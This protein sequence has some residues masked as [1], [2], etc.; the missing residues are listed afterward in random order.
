[1]KLDSWG[2]SPC[3]I[4]NIYIV[5]WT[6]QKPINPF[7][8][9][10]VHPFVNANLWLHLRYVLNCLN[11]YCIWPLENLISIFLSK[12]FSLFHL[13][14]CSLI[15]IETWCL[16]QLTVDIELPKTCIAFSISIPNN[17]KPGLMG[18][19]KKNPYSCPF[20][21]ALFYVS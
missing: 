21:H 8:R 13:D 14:L 11:V 3:I 12:H 7:I 6:D 9:P 19:R 18:N 16:E 1:M 2:Y 4:Y 15:N 5:I 20:R 10:S 17:S